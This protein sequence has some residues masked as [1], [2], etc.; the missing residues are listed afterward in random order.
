MPLK[1]RI[2]KLLRSSERYFKTDMVYLARGGSWLTLGQVFLTVSS[3][4]LTLAYAN[5]LPKDIFGTYKYVLSIG[6]VLGALTLTGMGPALLRATARGVKDI[7]EVAFWTQLKW[8][9][10]TLSATLLGAGYYF[11]NNNHLLSISL[12]IVGLFSPLSQSA[13]LYSSFLIGKKEFRTKVLYDF[14]YILVPFFVIVGVLFSTDDLLLLV[15]AYFISYT[16]VAVFLYKKVLHT[17]HDSKPLPA[18]LDTDTI[19]YAKHLSVINIFNT[20]AGQLDKVLIFHYLGAVQLAVYALALAP[21]THMTGFLKSIHTLSLP[22]LV[23][24]KMRT[25]Q[26]TL[27]A[28]A[29]RLVFI[30]MIPTLLYIFAAPYLYKILFPKYIESVIYSQLYAAMI[31]L[32]PIEFI[33]TSVTAHAPARSLYT[34]TLTGTFIKVG[35]LGILLPLYGILGAILAIMLYTIIHG[36]VTYYFFQNMRPS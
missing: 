4:F 35:L 32:Y 13:G 30:L 6:G 24:Q 23:N 5:L 19:S 3:F 36:L 21:I 12:L 16:C 7:L 34:L 29:V 18:S 2:H 14:I 28:K 27:P 20:V 26:E 1:T 11:I 9:A 25:I 17:Y 33:K 15:L 8:S 10:L 22:K 31:L